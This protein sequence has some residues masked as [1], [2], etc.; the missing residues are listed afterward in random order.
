MDIENISLSSIYVKRKNDR[1]IFQ[2][3]M[4]TKVK[5]ILLIATKYDAYSIVREG[6][7][8]D[9]IFGEYLQL[10]LY[11]APR[12][13]SANTLDEA[14]HTIKK[15]H[16]DM[17]I[18]MA[19]TNRE[20]PIETAKEINK[21]KSRLPIL[22]LVNNNYD[23]GYFTKKCEPL[24]FIDRV[25]VWNGNTSIFLAMIKYIED[26]K[27]VSRDVK[28]GNVR[29]ILLVE[30]SV[31]YYSRYLPLLYTSVMLQTQKLVSD[32]AVDEL[33]KILEMRARPKI[34]L[35]SNYEDATKIFDRYKDNLLCVISDVRFKKNGIDDDE[36]GVQ[37]L[38]YVKQNR[39]YPIPLMMQSH[40][41]ENA[42]R[43]ENCNAEFIHKDSESLSKELNDFI[44]RRL[45]FG[46]FEFMMP[47]G[48]KIAEA[49]SLAE[50]QELIARVPI[51][52]LSYHGSKNAFSRWLMARG[53]INIAEQLVPKQPE[54]FT[55]KE[56]L[57]KFM[58]QVFEKIKN[59]QLRGRIIKFDPDLLDSNRYITRLAKGSLGGKGRGLAFISN[60]IENI[61]FKKIIPNI[62]IRMPAT[63]IIGALEFDS[64]I[65]INNLYQKI[66]VEQNNEKV[67]KYF[68]N[69]KFSE[70][71][72]QKLLLY[73]K[74]IN[75]P[76]A[77]RSSGLFE[78]SLLQPFSGVY[79]TYLLPNNHP[80]INVR[81]NQLQDA[82][83]LVYASTFDAE[84]RSYFKAVNYK[85]EEE[86]MAVI[87][88]EV[89]GRNFDG[90]FY[91]QVSG[92]A[93]SYNYYPVSYMKPEDGFSV[94]GIGLGMYIVGGEKSYRFCPKYPK[95]NH[96]SIKD[97]LRDS[98]N[99]FYA[100]DMTQPAIDL[101]SGN[102]MSTIK[103]YKIR[104][105]IDEQT[106]ENCA[107]TFDLQNDMLVP[108]IPAK[109]P[110]VIDFANLLKYDTIPLADSLQLLL[111]IFKEAMGTPVEIE[112]A[113]DLGTPE[114]GKLPT[115]YL[116]QIKPLIRKSNTITVDLNAI[117]KEKTL[118]YAANGMGNGKIETIQDVIYIDPERFD[119]T[120]TKEIVPELTK[121]NAAFM[122]ADKQYI[123]IGPGRWGT[124]DHFT[125]IPVVWSQIS[126]AKV[127]I[128]MG[129]KDFQLD[130]SLGSHFFHNVTSMNVG[131]YSV[132]YQSKEGFINID[133][134]KEAETISTGK[135]INH[136]KFSQPLNIQMDGR[137]RA[138]LIQ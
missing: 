122:E 82:I 128:E 64:F 114:K 78:D 101:S 31:K 40:D 59:E 134:L 137:K 18:I 138:I 74:R 57:R 107:S 127:I 132:P 62:N 55:E 84:A 2:E 97:Q 68:L 89:V 111:K 117:K 23:L 51:D 5:E 69:G 76:L 14:L 60:F 135:Y 43:A 81:L 48:R 129:L 63:A 120:K 119:S 4:P 42:K 21:H 113:L 15:R 86:K 109:G 20:T 130:A 10:N 75:C 131:Y 24:H 39:T 121:L 110:R 6:Q 37:L 27:N 3:L 56:D 79:A 45:G 112:Y 118:L 47:D 73:L 102:E 96:S 58:L 116:L 95:I 91:P 50:F 106:L 53:E 103:K 104:A 35:V 115:F 71:L 105:G 54:Q 7:F 126:S 16:F 33:H 34:L 70:E 100:I 94:T 125:G 88:Q 49:H 13:T 41:L 61:D 38:N 93:Q 72:S 136:V 85:V 29:V 98:Q 1:D 87:I 26:K 99:E 8:S 32:D 66:I 28:L 80:D 17:V 44:H 52:S 67:N 11:S 30:D 12:F 123:L 77:V 124:K 36:A 9:K 108:G 83:K 22:L 46:N 92:V 65:E 25:F 133:V 90:K 19:S